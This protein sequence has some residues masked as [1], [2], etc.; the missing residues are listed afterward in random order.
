MVNAVVLAADLRARVRAAAEG[1]TKRPVDSLSQIKALMRD[2]MDKIAAQI[3]WEGAL[4]C[5]RLWTGEAREAF[6]AFAELR[7]PDF[8]K[9]AR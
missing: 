9:A 4:F 3:S 1:L 6:A 7:R 5:E 8:S 2:D